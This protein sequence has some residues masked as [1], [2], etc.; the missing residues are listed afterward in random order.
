[1]NAAVLGARRE[2][3]RLL[4]L[5][6]VLAGHLGWD[7]SDKRTANKSPRKSIGKNPGD[8]ISHPNSS[9]DS[10]WVYC[11]IIGFMGISTW[12]TNHSLHVSIENSCLQQPIRWLKFL[13]FRA[14]TETS[15]NNKNIRKYLTELI[16]LGIFHPCAISKS[17]QP[18]I[19]KKKSQESCECPQQD[20]ID[21][22]AKFYASLQQCMTFGGRQ[23]HLHWGTA[24]HCSHIQNTRN[25]PVCATYIDVPPPKKRYTLE[26]YHGT[27]KWW[28]TRGISF[29]K[30]SIF[31]RCPSQFFFGGKWVRFKVGNPP[32]P[33]SWEGG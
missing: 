20:Q 33:A 16:F 8:Q 17:T 18:I 11:L 10:L 5:V 7:N 14:T 1:M 32:E 30:G 25:W 24:P 15:N 2:N 6:F 26:N 21:K 4:D 31:Y 23:P 29:S 22:P 19:N 28:F 3:C 13:Q 9:G 27:L 12:K